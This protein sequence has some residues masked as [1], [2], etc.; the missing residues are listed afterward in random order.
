MLGN[1]HDVMETTL[2]QQLHHDLQDA[3]SEYA[4]KY[5]NKLSSVLKKA[6]FGWIPH[7]LTRKQMCI[8]L[9][10][11]YLREIEQKKR[12]DSINCKRMPFSKYSNHGS[13]CIGV[14]RCFEGVHFHRE[15]T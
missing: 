11:L 7:R 10:L 3:L 9:S 12:V 14:E 2:T 8:I 1:H 4:E 13:Q 15:T 6:S 5:R